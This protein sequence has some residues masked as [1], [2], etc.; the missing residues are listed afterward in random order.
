MK[1]EDKVSFIQSKLLQW[2]KRDGRSYHWRNSGLSDYQYIVAE[3]LLQRTKADTVARYYIQFLDKFPD[4]KSLAETSN[5]DL[6]EILKP[7][8]LYN[9]RAARLRKLAHEMVHRA[10]LLPSDRKELEKIP[11]FGQ[12]IS[13]AIELIIFNRRMPLLDVNMARVVERLFRPRK[14]ADIRYD[15]YLQ[16]LAKRIV[17]HP[18][19]KELNWAILDFAAIICKARVPLCEKCFLNTYCNYYRKV[20]KQIA[21]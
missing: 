14:L 9:Q 4:W 10:N 5:N 15:P 6:E 20:K 2:Y 3:V 19:S 1:L 16:Q 18:K 7:I 11:F 13:N 12:Y 17:N 8:G 21:Q